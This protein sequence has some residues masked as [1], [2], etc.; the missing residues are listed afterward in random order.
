MTT[1][2]LYRPMRC[3]DPLDFLNNEQPL[4]IHVDGTPL[5]V[6]VTRRREIEP[7]RPPNPFGVQLPAPSVESE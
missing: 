6:T 4:R 1:A 7:R 5:T 2:R 3:L